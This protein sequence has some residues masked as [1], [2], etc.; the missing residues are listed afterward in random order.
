MTQSSHIHVPPFTGPNAGLPTR[1]E[2]GLIVPPPSATRTGSEVQAEE[3]ARQALIRRL[4]VPTHAHAFYDNFA[5]QMAEASGFLYGMVNLFLEE[6]TFIGLHNPAED[7]GHPII[8]RT[9]SRRDGWCPDV[10]R[11]KKS[12]P[13]HDVRASPRFYGN[14]VVDAVGIHAYFGAPLI[15][16]E[17]G[18]VLG[19]VCIIDPE[20]R[21]LSD[22]RRLRDIVK[23]T[24]GTVMKAI[25]AAAPQP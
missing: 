23:G 17:T 9:M 22:A 11:R 7:S 24:G 12:L 18:I 16:E 13:L 21:L 2:R 3:E 4:G 8:G 1:S 10:V 19:T 20:P 6:Q 25:T 5:T 14:P 15:H